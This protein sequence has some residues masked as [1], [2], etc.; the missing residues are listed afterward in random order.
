[1]SLSV[2]VN[3]PFFLDSSVGY[4]THPDVVGVD[5]SLL[6]LYKVF[7]AGLVLKATRDDVL[8]ASNMHAL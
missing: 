5:F 3:V 8:R 7:L 6:G 4:V 2:E 1:M